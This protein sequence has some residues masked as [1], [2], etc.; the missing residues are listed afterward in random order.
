MAEK[1]GLDLQEVL[2]HPIVKMA[3]DDVNRDAGGQTRVHAAG[4]QG[5]LR[6]PTPRLKKRTAYRFT[7]D[8][9]AERQLPNIIGNKVQVVRGQEQGRPRR[10]RSATP[11]GATSA[12]SFP[13]AR[14]P[15]A[16]T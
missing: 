12:S 13:A 6:T 11:A 7:I 2:D 3:V 9:E 15:A 8:Q 10:W 1:T 5:V 14:P 4:L 16:T